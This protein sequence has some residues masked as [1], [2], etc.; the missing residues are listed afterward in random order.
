[1]KLFIDTTLTDII[2]IKLDD[3]FFEAPSRQDKSQKLLSFIDEKL[4]SIGKTP[5][6]LTEIEVNIGPGSFT[7]IRVGVAVANAMAYVL[8]I[9]VNGKTT[10][11]DIK[12]E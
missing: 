11:T 4:A 1:M 6:D 8:K 9:P 10:E 12:Y 7:G 5:K 3:Q 2:K